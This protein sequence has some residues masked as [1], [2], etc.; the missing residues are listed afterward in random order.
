M[1]EIARRRVPTLLALVLALSA[2]GCEVVEGV[3]KAGVWLGVV[4]VALVVAVAAAGVAFVRSR[5]RGPRD[6]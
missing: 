1:L 5:M 4:I 2:T 6:A 3:F